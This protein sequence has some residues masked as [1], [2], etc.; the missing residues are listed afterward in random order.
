M[1]VVGRTFYFGADHHLPELPD[2]HPL[3]DTHHHDY[4]VTVE[5]E[6]P[7]GDYGWVYDY[8]DFADFNHYLMTYFHKKLVNDQLHNPTAELLASHLYSTVQAL[9]SLPKGVSIRSVTV[10]EEEETFATW[11]PDP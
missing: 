1:N 9:T 11:T 4:E 10:R 5:L 2:D 6:G 3:A 7:L 8:N